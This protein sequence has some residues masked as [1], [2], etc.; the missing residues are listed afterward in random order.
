MGFN[1]LYS[2][3]LTGANAN[4][5]DSVNWTPLSNSNNYALQVLSNVGV[6]QNGELSG[7]ERYS[8]SVLS[9]INDQWISFAVAVGTSDSVYFASVRSGTVQAGVGQG[10]FL[11]VSLGTGG[12]GVAGT[13]NLINVRGGS[14]G[15]RT[16]VINQND[17]FLLT[18]TGSTIAVYQNGIPIIAATNTSTP[19]GG[20]V[21]AGLQYV[22]TYTDTAITD[23]Q[24]GS[25]TTQSISGVVTS[26][27]S[28]LAGV[29]IYGEFSGVFPMTTTASDGTYTLSGVLPGPNTVLPS[30]TPYTFSPTF[31]IETVSN[32]NI[33]GVDF[34]GTL[35]ISGN[36]GIASATV[37]YSGAAS[38]SVT[39]DG[40]GNFTITGLGDG[41]YTITASLDDYGFS[42][43]NRFEIL[44]G[45][46][47]TGVDFTVSL[48]PTTRTIIEGKYQN[49]GNQSN[50]VMG[51]FP[52]NANRQQLDLI[53][54]IA[55]GGQIVWKLDYTGTVTVN[56]TSW[57]KGTLLGQFAGASW[58][59]CFQ[60][61][62]TNPY[63][64]DIL[65]I[66]DTGG[67]VVWWL[68]YTGTVYSTL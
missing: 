52:Q 63:D 23:L 17:V 43:A 10:Y 60:Q 62:N 57:T 22:S 37:S 16:P 21:W 27:S 5:F 19:T 11:D 49:Q 38:G 20:T 13:V 8:G 41:N 59:A 35:S 44:N 29:P 1:V 42:P 4:P 68:D 14:L 32:A 39:A 53:Q 64:Y 6:V 50:A 25:V 36:A 48:G 28:P 24:L 45:N 54:I 56:P 9:G 2:N 34:N 58:T 47:I 18:A 55:T 67:Q 46:N 7:E 15:Q 30:L 40:S 51:A 65:Q 61:N 31:L 66:R 26:G 3:T 33:T 12:F